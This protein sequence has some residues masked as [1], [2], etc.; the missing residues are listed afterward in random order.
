MNITLNTQPPTTGD[1][2]I[3]VVQTDALANQLTELAT[4]LNLLT[5][6]LQRDFKADAKEVLA[7]YGPNGQ[8]TYLLGIGANP[9]EMDWLR[10]FRKFFV[11]YKSKLPA[12]LSIDLTASSGD[13]IEGVVLGVR[14]GATI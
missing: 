9:Q 13:I 5:Y 3:P 8:K 10:A 4:K 7:V 12:Q 14:G 11:D 6:V 1:L 2:I